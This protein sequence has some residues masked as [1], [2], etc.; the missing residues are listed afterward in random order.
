MV[1]V[2]ASFEH[3]TFLIGL[4][5]LDDSPIFIFFEYFSK[6]SYVSKNV[7]SKNK[8][9][10]NYMLMLRDIKKKSHEEIIKINITKRF[11]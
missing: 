10:F 3:F 8:F 6:D 11:I 2:L 9:C 1:A 7:V 5:D 4:N